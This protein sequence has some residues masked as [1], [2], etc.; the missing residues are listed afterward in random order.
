MMSLRSARVG[1]IL[2]AS[3]LNAL[4]TQRLPADE[5]F[6]ERQIRPLLVKRCYACHS[7]TRNSGGLSLEHKPGWQRG[8]DSGPAIV[9]GKPDD[10]LLIDAINY[11]SLEMPPPDKGGKLSDSEIRLLTDWVKQGA[12]DPRLPAARLGGMTREM[13]DTWW[14]FQPLAEPT[15]ELTPAE[16][17]QLV[18][19]QLQSS[20]LQ[21]VPAADR[22]TLIRRATYDLTGLPPT[23]DEVQAFVDDPAPDAFDKVIDRLLE[24][25][26][27]GVR[28]GRHWLDVV[29]Y[30]DTAGENTDRPLPHAWKYRNWVIESFNR[31]LPFDEFTRL[32][33]AGDLLHADSDDVQRQAGIIATGYLAI[34][35]RFGH[36]ID[37]DIH[38]MHEDVID[39]LGKNFLGLT[40]GCARCHDHKY[41][42]ISARDYYALYGI[43]N[44]TRFAFP[45]CEPK[46]QP[47]DL[48]P[49]LSPTRIAAIQAER[50][51]RKDAIARRRQELDQSIAE[52]RQRYE[53]ARAAATLLAE[54]HVAEGASVTIEAAG[55]TNLNAIA[56]RKGD[57]VQLVILPGGNHGADSTRVELSIRSTMDS[58]RS[59]ATS[60]LIDTLLTSNPSPAGIWSFLNLSDGISFL[61]ER[62]EVI[63]D[64]R[65]LNAWRDGDTPSVFVNRSPDP[66]SVWTTLP[67][68]TFF[69]HPGP[70]GPV[71]L[72]WTSPFDGE[73]QISGTVADAHPAGLDGVSFQLQHLSLSNVSDALTRLGNASL[74]IQ[75]M[76]SELGP[77]PTI[78]VAYAVVDGQ[79]AN[80]RMHERGDPELPGD[81]IPRRWL[82]VFGG[83]AV[84]TTE[85]SGR[86]E[87][88]DW[89]ST[90][91]LLA[92]VMVN[93]IWQG[94]F[95]EGL[96]R[97]PNDFGSRG[98]APTHPRLLERLAGE[99]RRGGYRLK[100][101]HRL[102][103]QTAAYQR[104]SA[105]TEALLIDDPDNRQWGRFGR[106]RL[107]AEELRDS[108]LAAS[109]NLDLTPGEAHPFP[110]PETW[111]FTQHNPFTAVYESNRRSAYLMVQRQRRHPYLALFD[112][113][114]PNASTPARE[115]TTVPTQAL[116]FLN[117]P[118]FHEQARRIAESLTPIDT[119]EARIDSLYRRLYQ[120]TPLAAERDQLL[121]FGRAYPGSPVEQWSAIAR[122][123]LASNEFLFVD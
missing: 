4:F 36:D 102:L 29:R 83:Q 39:N 71:A 67:A 98:E 34:A 45:G 91:P 123:M 42:P 61:P 13:A 95:G 57:I 55:K 44:S 74:E 47:R 80:V 53:A 7:G 52:Q 64:R 78:P 62:A 79:I 19:R 105:L 69:M 9:P 92:R 49:L 114:N 5:E 46:G 37:K 25:P 43:F 8:G 70:D 77:E 48:V 51:Q 94:H 87:L 116:Y 59:W 115:T 82:E 23:M 63:N 97:T 75:R 106:R 54:A 100:P 65:D 112:G 56:V 14:S 121:S 84:E 10:S 120:R 28:W 88:A 122:V 101:I 21:A 16:I 93:R 89:V 110:A 117:D 113:A 85:T 103:M 12:F 72:A 20:S 41:D 86:H 3:A 40:L 68:R 15:A 90:H 30:A 27:Y 58:T 33:I 96:V 73:I 38:L 1:I 50:Q 22:R 108:L 66:V 109:G 31:D 107:S 2:F 24:S 111:S 99:F 118:F 32:Q 81:E 60:D 76:T 104:S 18:D 26:Q 6:F 11:R 119:D 17:D 35:R